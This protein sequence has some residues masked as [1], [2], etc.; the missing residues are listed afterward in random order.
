[1]TA[2]NSKCYIG[3]GSEEK[4]SCKGVIQK[5]NSLST[6]IYNRVLET[7]ETHMATNRGFKVVDHHVTTYSQKKRGL[8]Y[9]YIKRRVCADGVSTQP[10]DI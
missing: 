7:E 3:T 2:L 6:Q 1:M 10:L 8:S 9:Q 4:I 5:Q